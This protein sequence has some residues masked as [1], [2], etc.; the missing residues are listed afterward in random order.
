MP[1]EASEYLRQ[2]ACDE[3]GGSLQHPG[4]EVIHVK[5]FFFF[6]FFFFIFVFRLGEREIGSANKY[7]NATNSWHFHIY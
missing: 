4:A 6:F 7:E 5:P 1:P 3:R 2:K